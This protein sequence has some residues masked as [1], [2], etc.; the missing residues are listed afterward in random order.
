M[1]N[2][3]KFEGRAAYMTPTTSYVLNPRAP[4]PEDSISLWF[5]TKSIR[6]K[7]SSNYIPE[8]AFIL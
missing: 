8:S 4:I 2:T 5:I 1:V 7:K 3:L 6:Q